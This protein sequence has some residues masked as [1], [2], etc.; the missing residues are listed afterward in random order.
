[1]EIYLAIF[2]FI[3][4][5]ALGSQPGERPAALCGNPGK[6]D[7]TLVQDP[8]FGDQD[9]GQP[10]IILET[11]YGDASLRW[12]MIY[13]NGIDFKPIVRGSTVNFDSRAHNLGT[14]TEINWENYPRGYGG[15]SVIEGN[16]GA[17]LFQSED[18]GAPIMGFPNNLI[19][20]APEECRA[21]KDSQSPALKPTDKD[22]Y[23]QHTRE[24]TMGILD[25]ER[26]SI[27]KNYTA[28]AMSHSGRFK[29]TFLYGYH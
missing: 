18:A 24:F 10:G 19:P 17:V 20:I 22:G 14:W 4:R 11:V 9:F 3:A 1:M 26:V 27:H 21:V 28:T 2:V 8:F 12:F 23:D 7:Y 5:V 15:V 13:Q 6:D 16:D 29:V 25:D